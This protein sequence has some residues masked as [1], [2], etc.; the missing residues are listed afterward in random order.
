MLTEILKNKLADIQT[1]NRKHPY[2][3]VGRVLCSVEFMLPKE[4]NEMCH[5]MTAPYVRTSEVDVTKCPYN[6]AISL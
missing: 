2:Y 3:Y 4:T 5:E 1:K 6:V